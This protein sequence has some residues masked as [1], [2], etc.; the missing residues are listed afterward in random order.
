ME[1]KRLVSSVLSASIVLGMGSALVSADT[2]YYLNN[3]TYEDITVNGETIW[4]GADYH[5]AAGYVTIES[6]VPF[7]LETTDGTDVVAISSGTKDAYDDYTTVRMAVNSLKY[8]LS[9]MKDR[10]E[11]ER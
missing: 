5:Q 8:V 7:Y 9:N 1:F 4:D 11:P 3:S 2:E 10:E 6:T